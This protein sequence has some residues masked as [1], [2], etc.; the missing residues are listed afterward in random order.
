MLA[1]LWASGQLLWL[2]SHL[3]S[4]H[5][6]LSP[7]LAFK[8]FKYP[9]YMWWCACVC[10]REMV[11]VREWC[12][13]V[14]VWWSVVY[15]RER[16][17]WCV[18][19]MVWV[20][21]SV[22]CCVV[23]MWG[24]CMCVWVQDHSWLHSKFRPICITWHPIF[25]NKQVKKNGFQMACTC[26]SSLQTLGHWTEGSWVAGQPKTPRDDRQS[27]RAKQSCQWTKGTCVLKGSRFV[28]LFFRSH[29][30][31]NFSHVCFHLKSEN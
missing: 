21:D 15:E 4:H 11:G 10:E 20:W 23:C 6:C 2:C 28:C 17:V 16:M 13:M 30:V 12:V 29:K 3:P 14:C 7:C 5:R 18:C 8:F 26:N 27:D 22:W 24:V 31:H 9:V 1:V 19:A 25:K